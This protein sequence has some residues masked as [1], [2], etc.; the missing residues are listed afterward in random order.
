M[1]LG[2]CCLILYV[3][4][5]Q[6][7]SISPPSI[8]KFIY[9]THEKKQLV[10]TF[11]LL[12]LTTCLSCINLLHVMHSQRDLPTWIPHH[13][14][15][16]SVDRFIIS[17]PCSC[18]RNSTN[19]EHGVKVIYFQWNQ[20]AAHIQP[21]ETVSLLCLQLCSACQGLDR[22][23]HCAHYLQSTCGKS[24]CT[25]AHLQARCPCWTQTDVTLWTEGARETIK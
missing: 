12:H 15:C 4:F 23:A 16:K 20:S 7:I 24:Q 21:R 6:V 13:S 2:S 9:I 18:A 11:S 22:E 8:A 14:I 3:S 1:R 10:I 25:P 5:M 17:L 19:R